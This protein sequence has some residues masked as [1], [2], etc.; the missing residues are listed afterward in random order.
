MDLLHNHL[1][2]NI[3]DV[4]DQGT[5]KMSFV[6]CFLQRRRERRGTRYL[7]GISAFADKCMADRIAANERDPNGLYDANGASVVY[8]SRVRDNATGDLGWVSGDAYGRIGDKVTVNFDRMCVA[9]PNLHAIDYYA[10]ADGR[11]VGLAVE[12][13]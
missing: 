11:V 2:A 6:N 1:F 3:V 12:R 8:G 4:T 9:Y 7:T 5:T 13:N 10:I